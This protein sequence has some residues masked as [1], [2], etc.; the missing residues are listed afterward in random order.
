MAKIIEEFIVIKVSK[1]ARDGDD[2]PLHVMSDEVVS[3]LTD[4]AE[5]ILIT[6]G[7]NGCVVEITTQ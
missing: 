7:V 3:T 5:Q 4:A 2:Q 1:I 6:T